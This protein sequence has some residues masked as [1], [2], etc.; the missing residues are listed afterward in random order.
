MRLVLLGPPGAGKGTQA[1]ILKG[2]YGYSHISTGEIF[3]RHIKEKTE[4]GEKLS[5]YVQSGAL[6]PDEIVVEMVTETIKGLPDKEKFVLDGFPRT[7]GQARELDRVLKELNLE[8]DKVLYFDTTEEKIIERLG[9][10]RICSVC[11]KT[12]HIKNIPPKKEG[13]CD[14]CGGELYQRKD[15]MPET[16]KNR[17]K[18]Y[19]EQTEELIKY[20]NDRGIL[21]YI[22]GDLSKED[23]FEVIKELIN[24]E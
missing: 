13:I 11:G 16:I 3:R 19:K 4:L 23:A 22:N 8:L 9:G 2:K 21:E 12:Y 20:Y 6:V 18:V 5:K 7:L 14:V 17:L 24:L 1:E 15:D 10:R